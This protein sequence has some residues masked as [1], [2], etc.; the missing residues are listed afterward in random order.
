MVSVTC[1]HCDEEFEDEIEDYNEDEL[2][3]IECPKCEKIFGYI[4]LFSIDTSSCELPCGGRDGDG[5]HEWK[6][7]IGW[8][9]EHF[10]NKYYCMHCGLETVKKGE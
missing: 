10:E 6:K 7:L 9:A 1:P 5:P 4:I 8:P 3:E 2:H